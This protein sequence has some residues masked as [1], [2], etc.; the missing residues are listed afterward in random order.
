MPSAMPLT[1]VIPFF[2]KSYAMVFVISLPYEECLRLPTIDTNAERN[3][4]TSSVSV[5]FEDI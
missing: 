5:S 3:T 2:A 4:L 1:M